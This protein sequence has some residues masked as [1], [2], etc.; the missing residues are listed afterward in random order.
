[1]GEYDPEYYR[2]LKAAGLC[3]SCKEP[4]ITGHVHCEKHYQMEITRRLRDPEYNAHH[5]AG[6]KATRAGRR[7]RSVCVDC[8]LDDLETGTR[9]ARCATMARIRDQKYHAKCGRKMGIRKCSICRQAG[10]T[11][12]RCPQRF[13]VDATGYALAR[14]DWEAA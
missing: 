14:A 5:A 3:P 13:R 1:M 2:D 12:R 11:S 10:H 6:M 7:S 8:G 9:C 4:A